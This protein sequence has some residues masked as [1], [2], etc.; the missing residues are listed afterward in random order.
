[1]AAGDE[2][3]PVAAVVGGVIGNDIVRAVSNSDE[4]TNNIFLYSL[5]GRPLVQ[6]LP[7]PGAAAAAGA[8]Q[9]EQTAAAAAA[10][11]DDVVLLDD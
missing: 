1:V 11:V 4:P 3:A 9:K 5:T 8:V 2:F 6:K 10:A 7:P